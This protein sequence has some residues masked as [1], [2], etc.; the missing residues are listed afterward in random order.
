MRSWPWGEVLK[1][2]KGREKHLHGMWL[3]MGLCTEGLLLRNMQFKEDA[4]AGRRQDRK[5]RSVTQDGGGEGSGPGRQQL[6]WE[7]KK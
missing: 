5:E 7:G 6:D 3:G 4:S 2:L 1:D